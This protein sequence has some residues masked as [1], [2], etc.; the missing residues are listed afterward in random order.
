M[1]HSAPRPFVLLNMAMSADGK[2]ATANRRIET[3]GSAADHAHLLD[4]RVTTDAVLC[5]ARTAGLPGVTLD[6]GGPDYQ[7][8][9]RKRGLKEFPLRIVVSG[10]ASLDPQSHVLHHGRGPRLILVS[11]SAP[12]GRVRELRRHVDEVRA[13]GEHGV[14]LVAALRWLRRDL[15]VHRLVCEGGPELN[16]SMF[17][18]GLIDELH[19]TWCPV[20]AGGRSSPT[21]VEGLGVAKLGEARRVRLHR[22][23]RVGNET[24]LV[25]RVL[26][27]HP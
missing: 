15:K 20:I 4:L 11:R 9:R 7:A 16:D 23:R 5:G 14:D 10:S 25:Y 6:P 17:R 1:P 2:V 27:P 8:L 22:I 26:A 19:L 24:F 3:F 13:F 12:A 21:W 18:S